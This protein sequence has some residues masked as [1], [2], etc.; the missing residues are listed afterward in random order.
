MGIVLAIILMKRGGIFKKKYTY[1]EV[2][3]LKKLTPAEFIEI[4]KDLTDD[5]EKN[6]GI[7]RHLA[8]IQAYH[9]SG[10]GNSL[11]AREGLNLFG[12]KPP[13]KIKV[14]IDKW[15]QLGGQKITLKTKEQDK[16]G[17]IYTIKADFIKFKSWYD[18]IDY[19]GT[20]IKY[21]YPSA[22]KY[23]V[24]GNTQKFFEILSTYYATDI[25]YLTK[26]INLSKTLPL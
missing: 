2:K 24:E 7:K 5:L 8:I 17:L 11:L 21:G 20:L 12:I 23:A 16:S 14:L 1:D 22:Y 9:E 10:Y 26:M 25:G 19:W 18:S 15:E 3:K 6:Y 4:M 13:A